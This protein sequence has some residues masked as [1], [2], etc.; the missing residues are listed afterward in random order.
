MYMCGSVLQ[1]FAIGIHTACRIRG[2]SISINVC[3]TNLE[4]VTY[5]ICCRP[6]CL[7]VEDKIIVTAES[8]LLK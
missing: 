8:F 6:V 4:W 2:I 1:N 7:R 3:R 5:S